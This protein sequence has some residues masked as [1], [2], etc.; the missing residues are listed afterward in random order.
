MAEDAGED[1]RLLYVALT[2]AQSQLVT[3]W[4][5]SG[6]NT[7]AAPLHRVLYGRTP[8]GVDVPREAKLHDDD[9]AWEIAQHWQ[10]V[11]GPHVERVEVAAPATAAADTAVGT[12]A[13]RTF[14]RTVDPHWRRTSYTALSSAA[15]QTRTTTEQVV[16]AV[17]SE[18][19][20]PPR[21]D[22][23]DAAVAGDRARRDPEPPGSF[24]EVRSPMADLPVGATFGSLVHAVLEHT[25]PAAPDHGGDLR[26][27]LRE[28]IAAQRVRW[29]VDLDEEALA[30]ALVKVCDTPLGPLVDGAT[31]REVGARDRMTELDFELPLAGG[32]Q[33]V[34]TPRARLGDLA[35]VLRAH[36]PP[37]DPLLPYADALDDPAY[38]EQVLAGYLTG[39]V[40]VLMRV[41][42]RFVVVDYKTNWLG[43]PD[44]ELTSHH[45]R[46][47]A[48]ADAMT[49]S[50]YPLQALLYA[51][52]LHRFLRWRLRGYDPEQHLGGV[53][54]LYLRGLCGPDTP[55]VAGHPAGVFSWQ[56]PVALV[57]AVSVLLDGGSPVEPAGGAP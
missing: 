7:T 31:L 12:L 4:L 39:S 17:G 55:T 26:A 50:S 48:L 11:G 6:R 45:Y 43:S 57:E 42:G 2:R 32:D 15:D 29:P 21:A 5:P 23:P 40:D 13:V 10:A 27:A 3:W 1:L 56:P 41:G 18:P 28:Q 30:D 36:L 51:V 35:P 37:G 44:E 16:V 19:E 24:G 52:V 14:D 9:R 47:E 25:D 53:M 54:Y 22:E 20:D 33:I 34:A 49:H 38:A 46:P 8:G